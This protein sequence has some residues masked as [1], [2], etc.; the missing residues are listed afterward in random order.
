MAP[1]VTRVTR[2]SPNFFDHAVDPDSIRANS[3]GS[4]V[5]DQKSKERD[6]SYGWCHVYHLCHTY[7]TNAIVFT[8]IVY[9][10]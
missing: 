5:R 4:T 7:G 3:S 8:Q 10:A 6:A 1:P 9:S 2:N